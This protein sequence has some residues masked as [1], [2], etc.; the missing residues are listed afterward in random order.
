MERGEVPPK[1]QV[2][3][4]NSPRRTNPLKMKWLSCESGMPKLVRSY[5]ESHR[6]RMEVIVITWLSSGW[7]RLP[8]NQQVATNGRPDPGATLND[9]SLTLAM[10]KAP[11]KSQL[12][13]ASYCLPF[14][15]R[16]ALTD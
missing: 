4:S 10:F 6:V 14:V 11:E 7:E 9:F 5:F 13:L 15:G 12:W 2:E 3:G 8:I 16:L 1:Q